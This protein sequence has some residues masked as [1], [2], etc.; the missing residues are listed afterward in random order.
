[1]ISVSTKMSDII[2]NDVFALSILHRLQIPLGFKE[3][4]IGEL[5]DEYS[6]NSTLF[7]H[8]IRLFLYGESPPKDEENKLLLAD[9]IEYLKTTH[10]YYLNYNIPLIESYIEQLALKENDREKDIV[11]L[12]RFFLQYKNEFELHLQKEE[13]NVFPYVIKLIDQWKK[14][15]VSMS[16]ISIIENNSIS[17]FEM[18][19]D[20]LEEKLNDLKNIIIK[21]LPPFKHEY[22]THQILYLL[23]QLEKDVF[24]HAELEDAL[25]IPT[26]HE[27]EKTILKKPVKE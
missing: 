7:L 17:Q 11:L 19:H 6:I 9:L 5:C 4:T 24:E 2:H 14:D 26:V 18:E 20:N 10:R 13:E 21:Y 12:K 3:K 23:F 16:F 22:E 8:I 27:L 1:M 15:S 25:L